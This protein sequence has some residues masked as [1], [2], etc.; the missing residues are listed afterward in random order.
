MQSVLENIEHQLQ[1][2]QN[3][4]RNDKQRVTYELSLELECGRAVQLNCIVFYTLFF[5]MA[6]YFDNQIPKLYELLWP[7][8]AK[9]CIFKK[10]WECKLSSAIVQIY[11]GEEADIT[12]LAIILPRVS[13]E[14]DSL[15]FLILVQ[16]QLQLDLCCEMTIYT[17][18]WQMTYIPT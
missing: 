4:G 1:S 18:T 14:H 17:Y 13:K 8:S 16:S 2:I 11:M 3:H 6:L 7:D 9:A 12:C 5:S 15:H 10:I